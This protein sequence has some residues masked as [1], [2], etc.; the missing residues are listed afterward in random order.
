MRQTKKLYG[1]GG[2]KVET[3][4]YL[5][6]NVITKERTFDPVTSKVASVALAGTIF[7][8]STL[9]HA[10]AGEIAVHTT[11]QVEIIAPEIDPVVFS[12]VKKY[13]SDFGKLASLTQR[14][15]ERLYNSMIRPLPRASYDEVSSP[16]AP[17]ELVQGESF[18]HGVDYP[19]A[20]GTPVYAAKEGV[21]LYAGEASGYGGWVVLQ[22]DIEGQ[23]YYTI[24]GHMKPED[25][26]VKEGDRVKQGDILSLVGNEGTSTGAHL[27]FSIAKTRSKESPRAF[28]GYINPVFAVD[29]KT[30]DSFAY[31]GYAKEIAYTEGDYWAFAQ[32]AAKETGWDPVFIYSQWQHETADFTSNVFRK[33]NNLAGQTWNQ[34]MPASI[35]GTARPAAEGGHYIRYKDPVEGYVDFVQ[36][37]PRYRYVKEKMSAEEQAIE[38]KRAGWAVD[39]RYAEKLIAKISENRKKF[40]IP[41]DIPFVASSEGGNHS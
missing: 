38:V 5:S 29:Q 39:E 13:G 20:I 32:R 34:N 28:S 24:Y 36:N 17:R 23:T 14:E 25:H 15:T 6:P 2:M 18:H 19:A 41:E 9:P 21:V 37:N 3:V 33:N 11:E 8:S 10:S 4:L 12:P 27:H 16:F 40:N 1:S 22:H 31:Q 7:V 30:S 35:K 26:K